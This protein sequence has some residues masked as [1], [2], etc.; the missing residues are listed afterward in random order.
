MFTKVGSLMSFPVVNG[1]VFTPWIGFN[2][3]G[4]EIVAK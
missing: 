4:S 1:K 2:Q 3:I